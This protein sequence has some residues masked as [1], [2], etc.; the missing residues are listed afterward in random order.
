M[1]AEL[2][3]E[4]ISYPWVIFWKL[5]AFESLYLM[6]HDWR[7]GITTYIITV[8]PFF[9]STFSL[10]YPQG[11][12]RFPLECRCFACMTMKI[13][14]VFT[15]VWN[16]VWRFSRKRRRVVRLNYI[17]R[18]A[19][20]ETFFAR[21]ILQILRRDKSLVDKSNLMLRTLD[22]IIKQ[23]AKLSTTC[24]H[25]LKYRIFYVWLDVCFLASNVNE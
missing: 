18:R 16:E 14:C 25:A 15:C 22:C 3:F 17:S 9:S 20:R 8:H 12:N 4:P 19:S 24:G 23:L 11:L 2:K 5:N 10:C 1:C 7:T 6:Q 13:M 21:F